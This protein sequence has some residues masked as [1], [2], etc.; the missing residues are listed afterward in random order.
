MNIIVFGTSIAQGFDDTEKGGWV[1]RLFLEY[2]PRVAE[3]NHND[4][5][6]V[7]NL[8]VSGDTSDGIVKRLE[9]ELYFRAEDKN[10]IIF[11]TGGNDSVRNLETNECQVP[12]DRFKEN[13]ERMIGITKPFGTIVFLGLYDS[14]E[15]QLNPMPWYEGHAA[16]D[17]DGDLYDK[18]LQELVREHGV[19]FVPMQGLFGER[20]AELT[21]DGDHPN[22]EG[23]RLIFE[24]VKQSL[25]KE[26]IL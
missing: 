1:N 8:G 20:V 14:D 7:F 22:A 18:A 15:S 9:H 17:A 4:Y 3:Q 19:H 21:Y 6:A 25:E 11:E 5:H 10:L 23:H 16:L 12:I 13:C 26:H 24:R 2:G